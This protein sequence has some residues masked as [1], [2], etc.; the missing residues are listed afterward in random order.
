MH[1]VSHRTCGSSPPC[2]RHPIH[3]CALVRCVVVVSLHPSP[4]PLRSVALLPAL[5]D[6]FLRVPREAQVQSPVR[7][8]LGDRGHLR[9]RDTPHTLA[10]YH[11]PTNRNPTMHSQRERKHNQF[12]R[13]KLHLH[14]MEIS[15][16]RYLE[17]FQEP[18]KRGGSCRRCISAGYRRVEDQRVDLSTLSTTLRTLKLQEYELRGSSEFVRCYSVGVSQSSGDSECDTDRLDSSFIGPDPHFLRIRCLRGRRH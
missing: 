12:G 6:V 3:A 4:F 7:L 16:H 9:P 17:N 10:I 2:T 13:L 18:E 8:P 14:N 15:E 1:I 5:P 11:P